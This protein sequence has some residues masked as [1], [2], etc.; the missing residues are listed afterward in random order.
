M[1]FHA[2][3]QTKSINGFPLTFRVVSLGDGEKV[4][5]PRGISR[6]GPAACWRIF[7]VYEGGELSEYV[8]DHGRSPHESLVEAYGVLE[9]TLRDE[10]SRYAVDRRNMSPGPLRDPLVDTGVTGVTVT[11]TTRGSGKCIVVN[12][13]Q[14]IVV[15]GVS[16]AR[17]FYAGSISEQALS[18]DPLRQEQKFI[19]LLREAV[20]VRRFYN[21]QRALGITLGAAYK[22]EDVPSGI[23]REPVDLPPLNIYSIMDSFVCVAKVS[24]RTTGGDPGALA[25]Q[26]Q[27]A[28]LSEPQRNVWLEGRCIKFYARK[29]EGR[30][31][32]L[33]SSVFRARN[34]WRIRVFH[35]DGVINDAVPDSE[36]GG[37]LSASLQEAWVTAVSYYRETAVGDG[38]QRAVKNP[39]LDTGIESVVVQPHRRVNKSGIGWS[40]SLVVIQHFGSGKSKRFAVGYWRLSEMTDNRL[41]EAQRIATAILAYRQ[42]HLDAGASEQEALIEKGA[43]IPPQ[44]YP[45][46]LSVRL[47]ADDLRYFSEQ[48]DRQKNLAK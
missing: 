5:V 3:Q 12:A 48:V 22:Y 27:R 28:D 7:I 24:P 25:G 33:P 36:H 38:R 11:R 26:L 34:E 37:D 30:T 35:R 46:E 4:W 13:H 20:A 8:Y 6:N 18:D 17:T 9:R 40:F 14:M 43:A 19:R 21:H 10:T 45:D 2:P 47:R 23:K 44:F 15:N 29:V 1:D 41:L 32:Y 39:L 31:F 16:E 42:H